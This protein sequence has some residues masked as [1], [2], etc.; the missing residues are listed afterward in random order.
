MLQAE[1]TAI[2]A[3]SQGLAKVIFPPLNTASPPEA[4][5]PLDSRP[6]LLSFSERALPAQKNS[7]KYTLA[8]PQA[9]ASTFAKP[10]APSESPLIFLR[11]EN[12]GELLAPSGVV[13]KEL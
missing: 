6:I 2:A 7:T 9:Q 8:A 4:L 12:S 5:R 1:A 13:R 3:P 10:C 11:T